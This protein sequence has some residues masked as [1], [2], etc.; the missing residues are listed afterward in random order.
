[1]DLQAERAWGSDRP[2][3]KGLSDRVGGTL[4]LGRNPP[5]R[6]TLQNQSKGRRH[7]GSCGE[8]KSYKG[9]NPDQKSWPFKLKVLRWANPQL[10]KKYMVTNFL[11]EP[12]KEGITDDEWIW[13]EE[14]ENWNR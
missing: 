13:K 1:M 9:V 10:S 14:Y 2:D 7:S 3:H 11:K 12:R 5:R 6:R 4:E 8:S